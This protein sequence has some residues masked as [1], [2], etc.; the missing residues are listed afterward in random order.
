MSYINTTNLIPIP[1]EID[2][3]HKDYSIAIAIIVLGIVA[4]LVV[5]VRLAYRYSTKRLGIDDYAMIP[6]VMFYIAWTAMAA[7]F[8]LHSGI[9]KPIEEIT[10]GEFIIFFKGI[11]VAAW[12]YPLMSASIRVSILLFYRRIFAK[13][14]LFYSSTIWILLA[15]Q[16]AYVIA[17]EII[18]G[19]SCH[20]IADA[21]DPVNR[22]TNC[23]DLYINATEAL[24]STS[25]AFDVILLI[26]PIY[27]ISRLQMPLKKRLGVFVIFILGAAAGIVA[28]YKLRIFVYETTHWEPTDPSWWNFEAAAYNLPQYNDYGK[29]FWIPSQVEPTVAMIG[30]SL[31]ALLQ[32]Y[33]SA[34]LQFSKICSHHDRKRVQQ[35]WLKCIRQRQSEI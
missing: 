33:A 20:P 5:F 9:G 14:Y 17:F 21:W 32:L 25:L 16:G 23:S 24:Y 10:Y 3:N 2:N 30:T 7:Y 28:A 4:S 27:A 11:F 31:P 26:F 12:M 29:T 35:W 34:S 19:F 18:P 8:N 22:I 1:L 6:A 13:G 15:L